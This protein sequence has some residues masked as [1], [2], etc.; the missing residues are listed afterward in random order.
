[1]S[2]LTQIL[3]W[4]K[5][6]PD[7]QSDAVRRLFLAKTGLSEQ[8]LSELYIL[9]KA[10]EGLPNLDEME[11]VPLTEKQLPVNANNDQTVI[12]E[13][14]KNL[15]HVNCIAPDQKLQ[16][17]K[18]GMTVIYGGNGSG[19]SGYA[20]V[21]KQACRSRD[22][23][24]T[25]YTNANNLAEKYA[26]PEAKFKVETGGETKKL[27]WTQGGDAEELLSTISVFDSRCARA[28]LTAEQDVAYL[29]YGLDI[30][31]NLAN[32]VLPELQKRL[33]DEIAAIDTSTQ[34]FGHLLGNTEVGALIAA[35]STKTNAKKLGELGNLT[36]E[37]NAR[38]VELKNALSETDPI[39]KS[40]ELSRLA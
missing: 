1:M 34:V 21:M 5:E 12:L 33:T 32:V 30:V 14:I 23:A 11:T 28:Y 15:N 17:S 26:I 20:R 10:S 31:E 29:P 24:D 36:D 16:F 7:W 37:D 38:I 13:E 4:T 19:K 22:Q 35:L 18:S 6:I 9:L 39:A 40:R 8:D 25:V 2:L 3:D 27:K